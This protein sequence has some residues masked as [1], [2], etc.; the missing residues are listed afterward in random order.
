MI[1][2]QTVETGRVVT[3]GSVESSRRT[4]GGAAVSASS[5]S[6]AQLEAALLTGGA[7]RPYVFGLAM[8]LAGQGVCLD[9]IGGDVV[10]R[11]ELHCPP[12]LN[13]LNLRDQRPRA[14]LGKKITRVLVYYARLIRYAQVAKPKIFHILWNNKFEFFDRT[15][16][17]L[18]YKWLG[19]RVVL[20][21]HNVNAGKR[22]GNDSVFNRISLRSQYRLADHIFVHTEKMKQELVED[23][24]L[25]NQAITVI[26]FGINNAVPDT[27]LTPQEAKQQLGIGRGNKTI[28]FFGAIRPYKGLEHLVS[29]FLRIA[30]KCKGYRL[31]IAGA[32]PSDAEPY[33]REILETIRN[34]A[35]REQVIQRI[36][37]VPDSETELYFK[38]ADVLVLPYTEVSQSGVLFLAYSFGLPVIATDVGSFRDDIIPGNTGFVCP[39]FAPQDLA[40][41]IESYFASDLFKNL[42]RR[43]WEIRDYAHAQNSWDAVSESTCKVYTQLL[44]K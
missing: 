11:P 3:A 43:R 13:F 44:E 36:E 26:P 18:Y 34:S 24:G 9:V 21:A 31:I 23:F 40:D 42:D 30:P 39:S 5:A 35:S 28:L 14:S 38:A 33:L 16:L 22:D 15:L 2:V 1:A 6:S 7:D 25:R 41:S 20:T 10:D 37:Y 17:M 4:E 27:D 29:A 12:K 8:A 32:P 19:K